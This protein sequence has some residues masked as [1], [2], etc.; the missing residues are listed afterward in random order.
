MPFSQEGS[1]FHRS[2][3]LY[4]YCHNRRNH[5]RNEWNNDIAMI[6]HEKLFY[7]SCINNIGNY[8]GAPT[9]FPSGVVLI[10]G[11][12]G[13]TWFLYPGSYPHVSGN[14]EGWGVGSTEKR[15]P[16]CCR[17]HTISIF[18]LQR[19]QGFC[20]THVQIC[21]TVAHFTN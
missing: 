13:G 3:Y 15:C 17:N 8:V 7:I 2:S 10:G 18:N 5:Y 11:L 6:L 14:Q 19:V 9:G 21:R 20:A 1:L 12:A 16:S 4:C